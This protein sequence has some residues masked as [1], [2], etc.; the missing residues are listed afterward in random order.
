[1]ASDLEARQLPYV[2]GRCH[3]VLNGFMRI[4]EAQV[5]AIE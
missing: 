4:L 5:L 1:M 3:W 2:H